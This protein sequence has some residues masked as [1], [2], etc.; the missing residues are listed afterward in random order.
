MHVEAVRLMKPGPFTQ[1]AVD[2]VDLVGSILGVNIYF[3]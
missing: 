3:H 1:R 2:R